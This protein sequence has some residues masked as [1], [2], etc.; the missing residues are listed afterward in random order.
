MD[1]L[2]VIFDIAPVEGATSISDLKIVYYEKQNLF[3]AVSNQIQIEVNNLTKR[4]N[5]LMDETSGVGR[6][7]GGITGNEKIK[8]LSEINTTLDNLNKTNVRLQQFT[9]ELDE[10]LAYCGIQIL[11][12]IS[13]DVAKLCD[14]RD[15]LDEACSST[16][17]VLIEIDEAIS[18]LKDAED[19]EELDQYTDSVWLDME[20][21][22]ANKRANYEV[23]DVNRILIDYKNFL[24]SI[25]ES[26]HELM[27][28]NF[29]FDWY[30]AMMEDAWSDFWGSEEQLEQ[31]ARA[32]SQMV[33]LR[34]QVIILFELFASNFDNVDSQLQDYLNDAWIEGD[35]EE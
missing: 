29:Q 8:E 5:E 18:A 9:E 3:F 7:F 10:M 16:Q 14:Y 6:F 22:D 32:Q 15:L 4:K 27:G 21:D 28:A 12:K 34:S 13:E 26:A 1:N 11:A 20:S 33:D 19:A 24:N 23:E 2:D 35:E 30:D 31:I 17:A 25:G